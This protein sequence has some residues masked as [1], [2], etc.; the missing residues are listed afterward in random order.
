MYAQIRSENPWALAVWAILFSAF[1]V[2][3]LAEENQ[4]A[5]AE[6]KQVA[7][8]PVKVYR[9]RVRQYYGANDLAIRHGD[10]LTDDFVNY[11][12]LTMFTPAGETEPIYLG[13]IIEIKSGRWTLK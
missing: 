10:Y 3:C 13:G 7:R 9:Y 2:G 11:K 1:F 5:M 8:Q 6:T 4:R 12:G